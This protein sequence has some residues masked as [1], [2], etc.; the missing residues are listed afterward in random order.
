[1]QRQDGD[2]VIEP[3]SFE[4]EFDSAP[5]VPCYLTYTNE[6]TKRIILENLHRAPMYSGMIEGVGVRYCPKH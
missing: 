5:Q 6:E 3:F 2:E 4:N 1:M